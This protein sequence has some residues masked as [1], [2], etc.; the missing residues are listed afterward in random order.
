MKLS[1]APRSTSFICRFLAVL[2]GLLGVG[3]VFASVTTPPTVVIA[4]PTVGAKFTASP[5]GPARV[6]VSF[7]ASSDNLI[8]AFLLYIDDV[9]VPFA[10]LGLNTTTASATA[11]FTYAVAGNHTVKVLARS[12]T[13]IIAQTTGSFTV[14]LVTPPPPTITITT[15]TAG[16]VYTYVAGDAPLS[17]PFSFT[18]TSAGGIL[19]NVTATLDDASIAITSVTGLGT[20]SITGSGSFSLSQAGNHDLEIYVTDC[21]GTTEAISTISVTVVA[22]PPPTVLITTPPTGTV[23]T[24][25]SVPTGVPLQFTASAPGPNQRPITAVTIDLDGTPIAPASVSGIGGFAVTGS[26]TLPILQVGQHIVTVTATNS[27]G[28]TSDVHTFSVLVAPPPDVTISNPTNGASFVYQ[29]GDPA[30]VIPFN[31]AA[32]SSA[33]TVET[34]TATLNGQP[35]PFTL[36]GLST[37]SATGSGQLSFT[38]A[39]SYQI[40]VSATDSC[41]KVTEAVTN[42]AVT[43]VI[44]P[45]ITPPVVTIG[46]PPDGSTSQTCLPTAVPFTFTVTAPGPNPGP[47]TSVSADI[48]GQQVTLTSVTGIGTTSVT[49]SG[50][51]TITTPGQHTL[52]A[53][54]TNAGGTATDVNMFTLRPPL[55]TVSISNPTPTTITFK[56]DEQFKVPLRFAGTTTCGNIKTLS[57]TLDGTPLVI[58]TTGLNSGYATGSADMIFSGPGMHTVVVTVTDGYGQSVDATTTF[59]INVISPTPTIAITNPTSN[60]CFTL[61]TGTTTMNVPYSFKTT[62]NNGFVVNSVTVKLNG[63]TVAAPTSTGLGTATAVSSGTL[64]GLTAGNYALTVYGT[65][66]CETVCQ[67]ICFSIKA[68]KVPPKVVINN[69]P[70]GSTYCLQQQGCGTPT[71][72]IPFSFTATSSDPSAVI[73]SVSV[74]LDGSPV[75]VSATLNQKTVTVSTNLTV[76]TAGTHTITVTATDSVGT[77]TDARTFTVTICT[78]R[79]VCG[80]AFFDIDR[81]GQWD[82]DEFGLAGVTFKLLNSSNQVV[83]TAVSDSCGNYCFTGV[84]PGTYTVTATGYTGIDPTTT[85]TR[86]VVVSSNDVC[87]A[88]V[89][90][91]LN[92]TAIR[93]MKACGYTIGFWKN[94]L[95]K[96]ISGKTNGIQIPCATLN[97]YTCKIA[98][99]G[100]TPFDGLSMKTA[101][102]YLGS[103]SSAPVSLLQKQL[104]ASEYNY[105]NGAYI[106]GNKNLT[107]LF[108]WWGE[109]L[110]KNSS[111]YSSTYLLNAKDWFN[112]YNASE[113]GY[114]SGP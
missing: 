18:A 112:A 80:S 38:T 110:V 46:N 17:I 87:V 30:L 37:A 71:L 48:D 100:L 67:S 14:E 7:N 53:K 99:F 35:L 76:T 11:S 105:M 109:Y 5:C 64:S 60:A 19:S 24:A 45:P 72:K 52:T 63:N 79:K 49:A 90:F 33:G 91:G 44:P 82:A 42:F 66:G 75:S 74:K 70:V 114:V 83:A 6:D 102:S 61:A 10:S 54:A 56:C 32:V 103:T 95:D 28:S 85:T 34:L 13:G 23:V 89:G 15:P 78:P 22:P 55:P 9:S 77:A 94:N 108:V 47:I 41:G 93:S 101:S 29:A 39:G 1:I 8:T 51:A 106:G 27:G 21:S 12:G 58:S 107:F 92:F 25:C 96:A 26:A 73:T 31:F 84:M 97:S 68:A 3:S 59:T 2:A 111:R 113:G 57:A 36:S 62:T 40:K 20:A 104:V 43:V 98:D 4:S 81:D 88:S 65:S 16:T 50:T 86:T 69:P